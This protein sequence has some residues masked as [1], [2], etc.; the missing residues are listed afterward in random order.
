MTMTTAEQT[1]YQA[2][3]TRKNYRTF[4]S[5]LRNAYLDGRR[6]LEA[7]Q[8]KTDP[9]AAMST[10]EKLEHI[11]GCWG[12][13]TCVDGRAFG[14]CSKCGDDNVEALPPEGL[15]RCCGSVVAL[16][17]ADPWKPAEVEL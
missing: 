17:P 12:C 2:W 13:T 9:W 11:E 10:A 4:G 15:S 7:E 16:T 3:L 8:A 6:D 1:A 5:A 14:S